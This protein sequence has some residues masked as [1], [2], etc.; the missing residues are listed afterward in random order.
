MSNFLDTVKFNTDGLVPVV[1][2]QYD[3][4]EVLMMAWMNRESL[5]QT[6]KTDRAVYW[7]RSRKSFWRKGD[8]SGHEQH[9]KEVR[10]DCDGDTILLVVDQIGAACHTGARTCFFVRANVRDDAGEAYYPGT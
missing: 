3:T 4:G 5:A 7:S 1:A 10:L 6:L 8:T 9:V 2:Q